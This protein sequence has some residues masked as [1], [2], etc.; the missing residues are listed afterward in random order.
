VEFDP[1]RI[2]YAQLLEIFWTAHDP[3]RVP[4]SRQ[5]RAAIFFHNEGQ[6][7]EAVRTRDREAARIRGTVHTGILPAGPFHRAEGY[8]QKYALRGNEELSREILAIYP[9]EADL[10]DSTAAARIN[11]YVAGYGDLRQLREEWGTLGLSEPGGR[12]LWG[13][14]HGFEGRRGNRETRGMACPAD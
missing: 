9:V 7:R 12:R 14:V 5:Y 4:G 11:G 10:V 2:T 6:R 13:I 3:R 8:H 1:V